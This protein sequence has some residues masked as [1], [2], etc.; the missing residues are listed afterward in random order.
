[1]SRL[2]QVSDPHF[3]TEQTPVLEA[4]VA[5]AAGQRPELVV[6]SGDLTQRARPAQF[7]AA[8][9]FADRL[10]AP[11]LAIP[12]NHDIPLFALGARVFGPHDRQ[13]AAFGANLEPVFE[14]AD[15]LVQCVNTTRAWRHKNGEVSAEQVERVARR[16]ERAAAT[17]LRVVVVH[18]PI[19]VQREEDV[20]DR[21]RGHRLALTRWSAAGADIVMGGHIH[22]PYV[23]ALREGLARP[24]WVV[25]AGTAVSARVRAGVPNSVNVVRW[26]PGEADARCV[27]EQWDFSA[28]SGTFERARVTEIAPG[29]AADGR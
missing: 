11:L 10:G 4:L 16:L 18:Q 12:G 6:L 7:S 19:A 8:K 28:A 22:L 9:A 26:G 17:Q 25:Q 15:W 29:R 27:V 2:L 24:L 21:L 20:P 13:C 1:M 14:S 3:G 5:F 23:M